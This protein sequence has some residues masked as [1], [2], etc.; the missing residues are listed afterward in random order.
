VDERGL[1]GEAL[2]ERFADPARGARDERL[3]P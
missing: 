1:G 3:I 2:R